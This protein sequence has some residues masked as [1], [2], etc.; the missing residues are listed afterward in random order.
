MRPSIF[1]I[2][3]C[4]EPLACPPSFFPP[5][6][7]PLPKVLLILIKSKTPAPSTAP[8]LALLIRQS[9]SR[10][11]LDSAIWWCGTSASVETSCKPKAQ[12]EGQAGRIA[13]AALR[14]IHALGEQPEQSKK[15]KK[16]PTS[17]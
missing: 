13:A 7:P 12:L 11:A 2:S 16:K 4:L 8:R 17:S 5:P 14:S 3:S 6:S 9:L 15:V 1:A 10:V